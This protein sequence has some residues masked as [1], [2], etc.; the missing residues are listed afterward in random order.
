ML[1]HSWQSLEFICFNYNFIHR[2]T[3]TGNI[4]NTYILS[5]Q[6]I[7]I[8]N[9]EIKIDQSTFSI[10][11]F[12]FIRVLLVWIVAVVFRL[13]VALYT[14][15]CWFDFPTKDETAA[16]KP[17]AKINS[18]Q[19]CIYSYKMFEIYSRESCWSF[20]QTYRHIS[21]WTDLSYHFYSYSY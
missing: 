21:P 4:N 20:R 12:I 7:K 17:K 18:N 11:L 14:S 10:R 16:E 19:A 6:K 1:F 13:F 5:L 9:N 8:K 15:W 2:T 3:A